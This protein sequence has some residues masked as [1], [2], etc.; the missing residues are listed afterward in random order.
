[1]TG[2]ESFY[3]VELPVESV[4]R[5]A[6]FYKQVFGWHFQPPDGGVAYLDSRPEVGLSEHGTPS[7]D[8]VRP[9]VSVSSIEE[10]LATA[11]LA[12]GRTLEPATDVGIGWTAMFE[13]TEGNHVGLWCPKP[14]LE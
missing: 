7:G 13:D 6:A 1:M 8:G 5:A 3:Y 14:D 11:E 2:L 12:G 10:T 4:D 9:T